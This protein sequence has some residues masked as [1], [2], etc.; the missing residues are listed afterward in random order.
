MVVDAAD[1]ARAPTD[2]QKLE[3]VVRLH[4][5]AHVVLPAEEGVL[6]PVRAHA[7]R[8]GAQQGADRAARSCMQVSQLSSDVERYNRYNRQ[9]PFRG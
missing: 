7:A 2:D 1:L 6:G 5:V 9:V 4:Q 8:V 3:I